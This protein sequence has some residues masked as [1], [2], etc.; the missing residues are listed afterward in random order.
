MENKKNSIYSWIA[1]I[2]ILLAATAA[3][4]AMFKVPTVMSTICE[5]FAINAT[6]GGLVFSIFSLVPIFLAIPAGL[7]VARYGN[8]K[9]GLVA[10][11]CLI[12]GSIIGIYCKS[13]TPLLISR[14]IEGIAMT[15]LAT[16]GPNIVN[17]LFKPEQRGKAM[18]LFLCYIALGQTVMYNVSP[19]IVNLFGG[20]RSVWWFTAIYSAVFMV[21]WLFILKKADKPETVILETKEDKMSIRSVLMNMD[22][23][24]IT[25]VFILFMIGL[26]GALNFL[27]TFFS[28]VKGMNSAQATQIVG[29]QGIIG[30]VALVLSGIISDKLNSRKWMTIVL[31]IICGGVYA[32]IPFFPISAAVFVVLLLGFFSNMVPSVVFA[33]IPEVNEDSSTIGLAI[34]IL[35]TGQ[36][37]GI[38]LS[39]I[40]F[41]M[42]VDN[43][44]WSA[45]YIFA[46]ATAILAAL[47]MFGVKKVKR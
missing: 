12:G 47:L 8:W 17:Q 14:I 9:L 38:F 26:Q 3:P 1:L 41:G 45:A 20:W 33:A 42:F 44:G 34:G 36:F 7:I 40:L 2:I 18:G 5:E 30:C 32:S 29:L 21:L 11:A 19:Y 28:E 22:I 43:V 23:W 25:I 37:V 13:L 4:M 6:Q 10:L 35:T 31:L 15:L 46:G 16:I 39:T 27:S 24:I